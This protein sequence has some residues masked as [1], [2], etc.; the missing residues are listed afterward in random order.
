[1]CK[2]P[3]WCAMMSFQLS[4]AR[5]CL[6]T[7]L[8]C[9]IFFVAGHPLDTIRIRLQ[10]GVSKSPRAIINLLLANEGARAFFKGAA[11]PLLTVALQVYPDLN[12]QVLSTLYLM[13][14]L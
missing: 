8:W 13:R 5:P 7:F 1:M 11:Y 4:M 9:I 3:C 14:A 10:H 6:L 12:Q 2:R